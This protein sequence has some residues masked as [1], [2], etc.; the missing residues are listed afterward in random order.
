MSRVDDA[1]AAGMG[2]A[3]AVKARLS[4]LVGVF[5]TLAEQHG[6]VATLLRRAKDDDE[7]FVELWPTIRRELVSHEKAEMREVYPAI[8]AHEKTRAHADH[9]DLEAGDL[10]QMIRTIDTLTPA[11]DERRQLFAKLVDTVIHH[12]TEEE[13]EIFPDAQEVLGK[14]QAE[15]LDTRFREA[16]KQIAE[17]AS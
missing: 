6:E 10:E 5:N 11:S 12:A 17:S 9:H 16:K 4:G 15:A 2:K 14:D 13:E 1:L 7:K 3:K 8:R